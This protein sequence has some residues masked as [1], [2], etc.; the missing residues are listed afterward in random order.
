MG[1]PRRDTELLCRSQT[2]I[3]ERS[4]GGCGSALCTRNIQPTAQRTS[5]NAAPQLS[6]LF[7]DLF[8]GFHELVARTMAAPK[9][10]PPVLLW[11]PVVSEVGGGMMAGE[12]EPTPTS[13]TNHVPTQ[14]IVK[15]GRHL[16]DPQTQPRPIP[17]KHLPKCHISTVLEDP[18][19]NGDPNP[20]LPPCQQPLLPRR[21]GS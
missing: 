6:A 18:S 14:T 1:T 3:P 12:V 10:V 2:E 15:V 8:S 20:P 17:T 9:V 11:R 19:R 13:P 21:N 7:R 16:Q 4:C 5:C